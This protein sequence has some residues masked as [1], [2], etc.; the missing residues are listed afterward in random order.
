MFQIPSYDPMSSIQRYRAAPAL[1]GVQ[2][3][4]EAAENEKYLSHRNG[5]LAFTF[6]MSFSF[7]A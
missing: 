2:K 6:A 4:L 3:C 1:S 7:V 5:L